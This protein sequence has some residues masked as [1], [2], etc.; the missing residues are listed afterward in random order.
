MNPVTVQVL[1]SC[2][3]IN[4]HSIS[5]NSLIGYYPHF[6]EGQIT[7]PQSHS[8]AKILEFNPITVLLQSPHT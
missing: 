6:T 5:D 2:Y 8:L 3:L 1:Y 4:P 7:C